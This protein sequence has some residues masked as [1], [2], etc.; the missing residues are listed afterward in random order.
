[1]TVSYFLEWN[2]NGFL[3]KRFTFASVWSLEVKGPTTLVP[4][5]T[6]FLGF[7][8]TMQVVLI[9]SANTIEGYCGYNFSGIFIFLFL[10]SN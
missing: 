6:K 2:E 7:C 1:M 8:Q 5:K 10:Q 9:Q 4:L 3:W